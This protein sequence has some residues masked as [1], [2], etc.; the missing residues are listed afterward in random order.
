MTD[1]KEKYK[2]EVITNFTTGRKKKTKHYFIGGTYTTT[3]KGS[4]DYLVKSKRIK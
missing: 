4:F 2:G 3:D 1:T